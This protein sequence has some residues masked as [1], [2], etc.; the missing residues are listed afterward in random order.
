MKPIRG[1]VKNKKFV[2]F[3]QSYLE[4]CLEK[5]EGKELVATFKKPESQRSTDQNRY[6]WKL[7]QLISKETGNTQNDLHEM[8]KAKFLSRENML[9]GETVK[10]YASTAKLT[11]NQMYEYCE[12]IRAFMG[13][14]GI[15]LPDEREADYF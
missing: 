11:I 8:F 5:Y 15:I 4:K 10:Y 6:Y 14:N 7:M 2:P 9:L 12:Q 13:E 3:A 1:T